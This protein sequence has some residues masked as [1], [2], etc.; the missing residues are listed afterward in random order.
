MTKLVKLMRKEIFDILSFKFSGNFASH[1]QQTL[2]LR[3]LYQ[4]C[5]M[6]LTCRIK[7]I[8]N[9]R[10]VSAISQLICFNTKSKDHVH[11]AIA[12][13]KIGKHLFLCILV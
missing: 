7:V 9:R 11:R 13:V 5:L 4:C 10:L 8:M 6:D 3:P 2:Y 1:C 12:T